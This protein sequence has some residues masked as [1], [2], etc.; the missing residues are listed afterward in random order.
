MIEFKEAIS[1]AHANVTTLVSQARNIRLEGA[2][3]S[4]DGALYE[5]TFSYDVEGE[6]MGIELGA[7]KGSNLLTLAKL[8]GKRRE[9]K[10][11]LVDSETG[12]FRGFKNQKDD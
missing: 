8:M 3:L 11:F 10:V 9:N 6:D 4:A 2:L 7:A 1:V 12:K 5:I